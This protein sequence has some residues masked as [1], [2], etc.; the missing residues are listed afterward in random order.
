MPAALS[1]LVPAPFG[2]PKWRRYG[3]KINYLR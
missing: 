1:V 2:A 3:K